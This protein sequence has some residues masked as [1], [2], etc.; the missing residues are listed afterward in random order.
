MLNII[1][2]FFKTIKKPIQCDVCM[3]NKPIVKL[4]NCTFHICSTCIQ[5]INNENL[6]PQCRSSHVVYINSLQE[7]TP[8]QQQI[9]QYFNRKNDDYDNNNYIYQCYIYQMQLHNYHRQR[10]YKAQMK[11][12]HCML[13]AFLTSLNKCSYFLGYYLL[14]ETNYTLNRLPNLE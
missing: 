5:S 8:E 13:N 12:L 6:C 14:P 9:K 2:R 7:L 3:E 1:I 10:G 4:C 11:Q